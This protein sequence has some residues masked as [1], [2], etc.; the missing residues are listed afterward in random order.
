VLTGARTPSGSTTTVALGRIHRLTSAG[1]QTIVTVADTD[2]VHD[3][4]LPVAPDRRAAVAAAAG[5]WRLQWVRVHLE[6]ATPTA[7]LA[8]T[9]RHPHV[10]AVPLSAAL[11][12]AE[13]GV[14]AFVCGEED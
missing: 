6:G 11:A 4:V 2:G 7:R 14:P 12:L 9:T 5:L 3:V 8:G 1:G 13:Q 10:R